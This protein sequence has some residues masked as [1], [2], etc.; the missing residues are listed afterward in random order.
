MT[1]KDAFILGL[2]LGGIILIYF[3]KTWKS[4]SSKK[5]LKRAKR[6][7]TGAVRFLEDRGYTI[8]EAQKK[9]TIITWINGKPRRSHLAVDYYVKKGGRTYVAEVKTGRKVSR[10]AL[11]GTRRQLLEYYLA[12]RPHGILLVDMEK[13]ILHEIAFEICDEMN[14][15]KRW[16]IIAA[17]AGLLGFLCGGL[18]FKMAGGGY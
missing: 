8:I 14:E 11:A 9:K 2:L 3:L 4:S 12:F 1:V 17:A 18:L 15:K 6:G 16:I 10:P 5:R 7:E 13:G